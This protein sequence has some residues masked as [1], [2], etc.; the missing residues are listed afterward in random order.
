MSDKSKLQT[1]VLIIVQDAELDR[2]Y[3]RVA[4]SPHGW[5]FEGVR[6]LRVSICKEYYGSPTF[7]IFS[8]FNT[9]GK[10]SRT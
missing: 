2:I 6:N 3:A 8:D 9:G 7:M 1:T 4:E 5:Q 10:L